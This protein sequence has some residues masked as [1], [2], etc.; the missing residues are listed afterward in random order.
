MKVLRVEGMYSID[1]DD[2]EQRCEDII[3]AYD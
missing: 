1:L 3:R 2:V